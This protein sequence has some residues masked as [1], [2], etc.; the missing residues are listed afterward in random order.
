MSQSWA[1]LLRPPDE[2]AVH[3]VIWTGLP[4]WSV[5]AQP[6]A[7]CRLVRHLPR[8][9]A[10]ATL[11]GAEWPALWDRPGGVAGSR[12]P[13]HPCWRWALRPQTWPPDE[14]AVRPALWTGFPRWSATAQPSA[15]CRLVCHLP[16]SP[17][18]AMPPGA[19][20]PAP[21]G[22]SGLW[23]PAA[24]RSYSQRTAPDL[25]AQ[26]C[27]AA[28]RWAALAETERPPRQTTGRRVA[29]P[30]DMGRTRRR[31]SS[32]AARRPGA[33]AGQRSIG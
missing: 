31:A 6:L 18:H 27:A 12:L 7:N 10:R 5:A 25:Q 1:T 14:P 8:P 20:W 33:A 24:A 11:P 9:P 26:A 32:G 16:R 15:N 17:A 30:K 21:W 3:L 22:H 13:D 29:Q 4:G 23:L 2:P 19:E 28:Q